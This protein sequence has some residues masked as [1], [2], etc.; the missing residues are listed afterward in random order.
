MEVYDYMEGTI[1]LRIQK[2]ASNAISSHFML[3]FQN[4][5]VTSNIFWSLVFFWYVFDTILSP[6]GRYRGHS[7]RKCA[8]FSYI[9]REKVSSSIISRNRKN[10]P[11]FNFNVN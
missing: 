3:T 7:N 5:D 4:V 1:V 2:H 8:I 11:P 9:I 10:Q 6:M